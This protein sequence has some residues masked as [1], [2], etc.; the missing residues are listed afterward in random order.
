[1]EVFIRE[2]NQY[3]LK[4]LEKNIEW[5]YEKELKNIL[6]DKKTIL[7]KPNLLGAFN[8]ELAVTTHPKIIEAI[9]KILI[10]DNKKILLG[11]SPG[12]SVS[13][14]KVWE[15]T[16]IKEIASQYPIELVKFNQSVEK[17]P[18]KN[19]FIY[20]SSY[21]S[22]ADAIINIPKLKTHSL[23]KYT[24]AVKNLYGLIPGL[25]KSDYHRKYA[26]PKA[27]SEFIA[28][29]YNLIKDK[30][31]YNIMDGIIGMEGEGPSSGT[32]RNF[33][34]LIASQS[35]A[36]LDYIAT[37]ILGFN[38]AKL[39]IVSKSL[40]YE[41]L[42]PQALQIEKKWHDFKI[43]DV[44]KTKVESFNNILSRIPNP[45]LKIFKKLFKY[46]PAFNSNCKLCKICV[47]S[48]PV[49]AIKLTQEMDKPE[50]DKNKCIKCMCCQ[51]LCPHN[52]IYVNKSLL[53]KLLLK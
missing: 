10:K 46:Y 15:K 29:F 21:L 40:E 7:L 48:C 42:S 32:T 17:I 9:I 16:G 30:V 26:N 37:G 27:F 28:S 36:G 19:D 52:A 6:S 13:I 20:L 43:K 41:N 25:K 53:A 23:V 1:M 33:G 49:A 3:K 14:N 45:I 50:I 38:P 39:L 34:L 24:G 12:G 2:I 35:A 4:I 51:E 22:Q 5:I 31:T 18:G 47:D 8:P 44:K 11:D